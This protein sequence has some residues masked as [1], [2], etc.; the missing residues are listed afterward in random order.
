LAPWES[1]EVALEYLDD[2]E[3]EFL[4]IVGVEFLD[5]ANGV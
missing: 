5:I 1:K 4:D 2:A 3:V